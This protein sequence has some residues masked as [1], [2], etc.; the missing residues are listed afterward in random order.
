MSDQKIRLLIADD[1][2]ILREGLA[3]LIATEPDMEVVG[4]AA[5][6][7][8]AVAQ[9]QALQPDVVLLDLVMPR[10]TGVQTIYEI[11]RTN[12]HVHILVLTGFDDDEMVFPALK[13]GA[14]GYF[15]KDASFDQLL[16]GIRDVVQ[17]QAA[18]HP[19]IA[20]KMLRRLHA[21]ARQSEPPAAMVLTRREAATLRLLARGLTNEEIADALHLNQRTVAKYISLILRK[22]G[23]TNRTQAAL[24]AQQHGLGQDK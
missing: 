5:D 13:E 2:A 17:G 8:E 16:Q 4:E 22:L 10:Q 20:S 7:A 24:Y 15:L 11:K 3:A 1:H 19:A 18:L 12:P 9:T 14:Q 6:G 21:E 23:L